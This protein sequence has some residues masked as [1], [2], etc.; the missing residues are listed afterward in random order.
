[1]ISQRQIVTG[2]KMVLPS[3]PPEVYVYAIKGGTTNSIDIMKTFAVLC[4]RPNDK[5]GG[6]SVYNIATMQR[7]SACRIIGINKKHIPMTD[8][9]IDTINKQAKKE[10]NG[11]EFADINL[12]TTLNDYE[13]F[14]SRDN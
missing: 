10:S 5:K 2:R 6:R 9:I 1:M 13:E 11:I 8:L 4:L 7:C 3:S 12:M 14:D